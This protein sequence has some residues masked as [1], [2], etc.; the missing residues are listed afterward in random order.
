MTLPPA[1]ARR[2]VRVPQPGA[3][4]V[5]T[6]RRWTVERDG[7]LDAAIGAAVR[8]DARERPGVW[9]VAWVRQRV[10]VAAHP[11]AA[12][13]VVEVAATG[14][15]G[16]EHLAF[17][18][19][20]RLA[21]AGPAP[22]PAPPSDLGDGA[23]AAVVAR[24][25]VW[26]AGPGLGAVRADLEPWRGLHAPQVLPV[27]P[28]ALAR[29]PACLT[30]GP[31]LPLL[32]PSL[33]A[34]DGAAALAVALGEA[35]YLG[36]DVGVLHATARCRACGAGFVPGDCDAAEAVDALTGGVGV[37]V[38]VPGA[39]A[40]WTVPDGGIVVWSPSAALLGDH[41]W[42]ALRAAARVR[43][44]GAAD[45][46]VALRP[47]GA[48]TLYAPWSAVGQASAGRLHV[49]VDVDRP[50]VLRLPAGVVIEGVTDPGRI[51]IG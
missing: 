27:A 21:A 17:V 36:C 23:W 26:T 20:A 2:T 13:D 24:W 43:L 22:T 9:A 5:L 19:A 6:V 30:A 32:G 11:V 40:L 29:C 46:W 41:W 51:A 35:A 18:L 39:R 12:R 47:R 14:D 33:P 48:A 38:R 4:A 1:L 45:A 31:P 8:D 15:D 49:R 34:P 25:G 50:A 42:F 28:P 7:S 37:P 3:A 44:D 10:E 16:G